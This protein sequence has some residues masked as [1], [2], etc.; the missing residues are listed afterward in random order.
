MHSLPVSVSTRRLA[1]C[2]L[3]AVVVLVLVLRH[4]RAPTA[5]PAAAPARSAAPAA[6]PV[7]PAV[8]ASVV[9]D[10][11]GAVRDPGLI[12]L[13][14]GARV[15]DAVARAGGLT[16]KADHA[17][18]DLA[19]PVSDGEQVLVPTT[20]SAPSSGDVPDG[21]TTP[22]A[23]ISLN[24]AT[25]EQLDALPGVGPTTAQKIVAYRQQHGAFRS[26]DELDAIPGIGPARL[27]E[28]KGLLIP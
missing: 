21:S 6:A 19:A 8:T 5:A 16:A 3:A 23:P 18:L 12:H 2:A 15:A 10:V 26:I 13:E 25:A 7:R 17:G 27:A 20:A 1:A 4:G 24:A 28:W 9:V 11:E 22:S 14:Q